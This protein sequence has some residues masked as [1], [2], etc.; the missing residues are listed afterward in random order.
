MFLKLSSGKSD[1]YSNDENTVRDKENKTNKLN[2][3]MR[4]GS[5]LMKV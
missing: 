2:F 4:V 1:Y 5:I 3:S